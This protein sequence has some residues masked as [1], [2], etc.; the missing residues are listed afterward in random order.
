MN[1]MRPPL[2]ALVAVLTAL[3]LVWGC[4]AQCEQLRGDYQQALGQETDTFDIDPAGA[5]HPIHFGVAF[6]TD[7]LNRVANAALD[8]ALDR[9]LDVAT[10]AL[11]VGG[12]SID[13]ATRGDIVDLRVEASDACARCFR[14]SGEL[15]GEVLVDLPV[16]GQKSAS[17][18][19]SFSLVAPI[20]VTP[21]RTGGGQ[22]QLDTDQ[23]ADIGQSSLTA[24]LGDL[25]QTWAAALQN[26]LS[27]LLL[28]GLKDRLEPVTL[29][30]FDAPDFGIPGLTVVP[31]ELVGD[32]KAGTIFAGFSTNI[33][34]L[35]GQPT[36]G[37]APIT[38]LGADEDIA[39]AFKPDLVLHALSLMMQADVVPRAYTTEGR[40]LRAGPAK[41]TLSQFGFEE[42]PVGILPMQLGFRVWNVGGDGPCFWFDGLARGRVAIRANTLEVSMTEVDITE[43]SLPGLVTATDW[44]QAEFI[45]GSKQIVK[46]SLSEDNLSVP[47]GAGLRFGGVGLRLA[48]NAIVL[49]GKADVVEAAE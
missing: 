30:T 13:V 19:G 4:G 43:A 5:D 49:T 25:P 24:R 48:D 37:V 39:L 26:E 27:K 32:A 33:S 15:G 16:V 17:L 12:Q 40:P 35:R 9:G 11:Q 42:G 7:L 22:I 47:G 8:G 23:L 38:E 45:K 41:V 36:S 31:V 6:K 20:I 14:V 2:L 21:T 10:T 34:A 18:G 3:P 46:T 1:R 28:V 44:M 29:L